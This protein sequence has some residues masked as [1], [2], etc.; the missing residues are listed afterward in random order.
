MRAAYGRGAALLAILAWSA[1]GDGGGPTG[2]NPRDL[3]IAV[4]GGDMQITLVGT[5]APKPLQ[6]VVKNGASKEPAKGVA[7]TW[8][9]TAGAT[10]NPATSVTDSSGIASTTLTLG[11]TPAVVTVTA[12]FPGNIGPAASF[13]AE[14]TSGA[15]VTSIAPTS[16]KA[17]D[18]ITV[19]GSGF[20]TIAQNN[21]VL[22]D[23]IAGA[24]ASASATQLRVVV[25]VCLPSR[26]VQ[27]AVVLGPTTSAPLPLAVSGTSITGLTLAVGQVS[28]L[29]DAAA[30]GCVRLPS[31]GDYLITVQ[32]ASTVTGTS[33]PYQLTGLSG[34]S[35]AS[36]SIL[37][38]LAPAVVQEPSPDAQ[39]RADTR[40]RQMERQLLRS[41]GGAAAPAAR[42][43]L[44]TAAAVPN[45]GDSATF[46][47]LNSLSTTTFSKVKAV[48]KLVSQHAIIYQ[49]INSPAG[50]G[51]AAADYQRF[52]NLFDDPIFPTDSS[53]YGAPSDID[54][55][56]HVIILFTQ[57]VNQLSAKGAASFVAGFFFG[58]DLVTAQ[59]CSGTNRA[60]VF[61]AAVPDPNGTVGP[62]LSTTRILQT[63]PP[64]LAHE[65]T[66]MIHWNQRVILRS[67]PDESLWLS[68]ALAHTAEDT[69][70][71]VILSRG[72]ST[73]AAQFLVENWRRANDYLPATATTTLL[74]Y[75]EPGTLA[76]RG[77]G[78]LFLKYLRGRFGG[79]ILTKLTQTTLSSSDNVA[80]QTGAGWS[81][82]L[83]DWAIALWADGAP[84]LAGATVDPRYTFP[85]F[86]L[87]RL[88]GQPAL[89]GVFLL[90]PT[91]EPFSGFTVSGTVLSSTAAYYFV[92]GS[93]AGA[94][95]SLSLAGPR[96]VPFS[97][98]VV[99]QMGI[100]RIR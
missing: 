52:G 89:G 10:V 86:D 69:V 43:Q 66:H 13:T 1:C 40:I 20:S 82:L 7:V 28:L 56:G 6:V 93:A 48:V 11:P 38:R 77:A 92:N 22:F 74:A 32:N 44:S 17:G 31:G 23:G 51:F 67:G 9:A 35:A 73:T 58:C 100:M 21:V 87:R 8:T 62:T 85:N 57:Q 72:D 46:N 95:L 75:V 79:G 33:M 4:Q 90:Q 88:L 24:V 84:Q 36:A 25:P 47:V 42:A 91:T 49:D 3:V 18:T 98:Q 54:A 15:T 37:A 16:A 71:A 30:A 14:G 83:N 61:Y 78:W 60:E 45:V 19:T 64:V 50:T 65:F 29:T 26:T 2:P 53:V 55:N 81:V 68:E 39:T 99:P 63:T 80:A 5:A 76:E 12:S 70:G 27:V 41:G 59:Q 97:G 94:P 34:G 96:G